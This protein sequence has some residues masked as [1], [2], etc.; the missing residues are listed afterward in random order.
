MTKKNMTIEIEDIENAPAKQLE[1]DFSDF[2]EDI[3]SE[4]PI[5][6][7]LTL[8]ALGDFLQV[9]GF[10]EGSASLVCDLCLEEYQHAIDIE[11]DELF[12]KK[13]LIEESG[14]EIELKEG[15]F[16]TDLKGAT[17]ID[18][19]DLLYQSVILDF[20]NKKVCG[21]NCKGGDIFIRDEAEPQAEIDPR[22]A[23]F[24]NIEVKGKK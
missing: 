16:V 2:I 19:T 21:I 8:K 15:Q 12:A 7:E 13:T 14:D 24:K 17:E 18:I 23:I 5:T 6:A 11:V 22:L 1:V 3:K 4:Q 20:P 10:I 9:T